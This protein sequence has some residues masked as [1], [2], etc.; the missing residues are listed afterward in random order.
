MRVHAWVCVCVGLLLSVCIER[1]TFNEEQSREGPAGAC[2]LKELE[3]LVS[4]SGHAVPHPSVLVSLSPCTKPSAQCCCLSSQLSLLC[5]EGLLP[6]HVLHM[7]C[8]QLSCPFSC[9]AETGGQFPPSR[10]THG[11][12]GWRP[13][14]AAGPAPGAPLGEPSDLSPD[15]N[16]AGPQLYTDWCCCPGAGPMEIVGIARVVGHH[17]TKLCSAGSRELP[18]L[19]HGPGDPTGK[20]CR[21]P[22]SP[23]VPALRAAVTMAVPEVRRQ[24]CQ[25]ERRAFADQPPVFYFFFILY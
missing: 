9:A 11:L 6:P 10:G 19:L 15:L 1:Q 8:S 16:P 17:L 18:V 5:A 13:S 14:S 4:C 2:C 20:T 25:E 12:A 21:Y 23:L 24:R 3:G 22:Y 7:H